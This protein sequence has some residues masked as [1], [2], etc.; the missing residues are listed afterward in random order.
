[1]S[2]ETVMIEQNNLGQERG[3][4]NTGRIKR[5]LSLVKRNKTGVTCTRA[6][7]LRKTSCLRLWRPIVGCSTR[8]KDPWASRL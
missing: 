8:R 4:H 5:G 6:I 7:S 1:M 3:S 2:R